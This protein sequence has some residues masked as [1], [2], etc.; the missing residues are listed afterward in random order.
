MRHQSHR[1]P[2]VAQPAR[3]ALAVA[4]LIASA[5]VGC[6]RMHVGPVA[7]LAPP[8]V[9]YARESDGAVELHWSAPERVRVVAYHVYLA[10]ADGSFERR[11]T[12]GADA[13]S[14]RVDGLVNGAVYRLGVQAVDGSGAISPIVESRLLSPFTIARRAIDGY[15]VIDG[16]TFV[17][18][19]DGA[20]YALLDDDE[21]DASF[22][23]LR[24][25]GRDTVPTLDVPGREATNGAA[26]ASF[27]ASDRPAA[28]TLAAF[29]TD[30]RDQGRRGTC[31]TFAVVAAIE[32]AYL[33]VGVGPLD[34]SEQYLSHVHR[35]RTLRVPL[36]SDAQ[37][38]ENV[39]GMRGGGSSLHVA[40]TATHLRVPLEEAAP[41][42]PL[43]SYGDPR[44][45]DPAID[46]SDD[47][48]PQRVYDAWNHQDVE[49]TYLIPNAF[50][51]AP[52]PREALLTAA[53]GIFSHQRAPFS[54]TLDAAWYESVLL[55]EHE[56]I[57]HL[58]WRRVTRDETGVLRPT[59]NDECGSHAV[60]LVGYDRSDPD[61]P[62]FIIKNSHGED[63]FVLLSYD[64]LNR[65]I[66]EHPGIVV[67]EVRNV[68]TEGFDRQL[69][70]GGWSL[71]ADGAVGR[72]GVNRL[73]RMIDPASHGATDDLRLGSFDDADGNA[74]RV[75]GEV[76]VSDDD[77]SLGFLRFWYDPQAPALGLGD[78]RGRTFVGTIDALDPT[79]MSGVYTWP[80]AGRSFGFY[81]SK[82]A[83]LQSVFTEAGTFP[84]P[85]PF[86]GTWLVRG[87]GVESTL[88][89]D[90]VWP[91]GA[92]TGLAT[93]DGSSVAGTIDA[94]AGTL[95]MD[96]AD[97]AGAS[98]PFLGFTHAGDP[99]TISGLLGG[100][101]VTPRG[102]TLVRVGD[103]P[104]LDVEV[105]GP[106]R[107]EASVDLRAS[108]L[109]FP[110]PNDVVIEWRFQR[111]VGG[112]QTFFA[113]SAS[114]H[115]V[116][117][118]LPC[119][120][121]ILRVRANDAARGLSAER[122]VPLS[123]ERRERTV[124]FHLLRDR[125]GWVSNTGQVVLATSGNELRV[126]DDASNVAYRSLM[127][128]PFTL[129]DGI[130]GIVEARV[131]LSLQSV[132]GRPYTTLGHLRANAVD[133]GDGIV[134]ADYTA[135]PL[136]GAATLPFDGTTSFGSIEFDVTEAMQDAWAM[137]S[138]RGDRLQLMLRFMQGSDGNGAEDM[139]RFAAQDAPG[140]L[141]LPLLWVTYRAY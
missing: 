30:V 128:F 130:D 90:E 92:F 104:S 96:L 97:R 109:R 115:L 70:L 41:Y 33:R 127:H 20:R 16:T 91:D 82:D 60:L 31:Q 94:V 69:A 113:S 74:H 111:E 42:V 108:A 51:H 106:L 68:R 133:F 13:R 10:H 86:R 132:V 95:R 47:A 78:V 89:I 77:P 135:F 58:C 87:L 61:D 79:F 25:H 29:Q 67:T 7:T 85:L 107:E 19:E 123:C 140:T 48:V 59:A 66:V 44:R 134:P 53:Y 1:P 141:L 117:A 81:A 80:G 119:D 56:V 14:A 101:G 49:R 52:F 84:D 22:A 8:V 46:P 105:L 28:F 126:G 129:P 34:L 100:S 112:P 137:R 32:A 136:P 3:S 36:P 12:L 45:H 103:A 102:V 54:S 39:L 83:P 6:A 114:G 131:S 23:W 65:D 99:G 21:V 9:D 50:E 27:D 17:R 116:R 4:L 138:V 11:D 35:M 43:D 18:Y 15:E 110:A 93:H 40:A 75:N 124:A 57:F 37:S 88:V 55:M 118:S 139:A 125:S 5:L 71:V 72:L 63:G 76:S 121:L 122:V 64:A 120:D 62:V 2:H 24:E 26:R 38:R 98:K 73:D